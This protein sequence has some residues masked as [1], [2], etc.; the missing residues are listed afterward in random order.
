MVVVDGVYSME[1]SLSD[2]P[3]MLRVSRTYGAALVV[4]DAHAVGVMGPNGEGAAAHWGLTDEVDII[5]GTF[6]KSLASIGGFVAASAPVIQYLKHHSRPLIFSASLP[7]ASTAGT[8]AAL[9]IIRDEPE[10]RLRLWENARRLMEGF[11]TL[12]FDIGPTESPIVPILVGPFNETM[13]FWQK[14]FDLG[15]FTNPVI[16]PAVPSQACRLRTSVMATHTA[17]QIDYCLDACEKIGREM[18]VIE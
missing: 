1:G 15:V 7:P 4:D 18:G 17:E 11:R 12:G 8:L 3:G 5:T 9:E 6:S 14:L 2:L 13:I 10:R 16:P